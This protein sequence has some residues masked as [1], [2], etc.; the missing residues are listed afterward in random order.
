MSRITLFHLE[1]PDIKITIE[2]YFDNGML[3][4]EG[5]DIGKSVEGIWGDS[6]YEYG[7]NIKPEEVQKLYNAFNL[8]KNNQALMLSEIKNRFSH[9][10]A[11]SMFGEFLRKNNIIY[12]SNI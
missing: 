12:T 10:R 9:N 11:Y 4:F 8:E 3:I 1:R 7:Y 5:Y 2:V 6:D